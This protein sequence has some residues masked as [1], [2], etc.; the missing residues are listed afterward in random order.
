MKRIVS[1]KICSLS[2]KKKLINAVI[3]LVAILC[4]ASSVWAYIVFGH[5]LIGGVGKQ[6]K[7]TRG[8]WKDSTVSAY[9]TL[10]TNAMY[11]WCNTEYRHPYVRTSI[12]FVPSVKSSSVMDIYAQQSPPYPNVLAETQHYKYAYNETRA[13]PYNEDWVWCKIIIYRATFDNLSTD[14]QGTGNFKREGTISHE[15]G[16]VFGL[17]ENNSMPSSVM[18]Q[19]SSGR[20][21]NRPS[22]DDCYGI[23]YLYPLS[24]N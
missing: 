12:W 23:N 19:L 5:I 6:G 9:S 16:H 15:M 22:A 4:V 14:G 13:N 11:N 10:I 7:F 1:L 24:S 17:N 3:L 8:Y 18:C 2:K 20:T 21:V